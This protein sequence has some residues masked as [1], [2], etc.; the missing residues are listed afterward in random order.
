[1]W[2][3]KIIAFFL[4]VRLELFRCTFCGGRYIV[5]KF[6]P[7]PNPKDPAGWQHYR[8]AT[9]GCGKGKARQSLAYVHAEDRG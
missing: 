2:F 7:P 9:R 6:E 3:I 4:W 8:C 1:M 5:A